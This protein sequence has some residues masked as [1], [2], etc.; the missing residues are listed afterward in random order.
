MALITAF[1]VTAEAGGVDKT[2][3]IPN[4]RV[5]LADANDTMNLRAGRLIRNEVVV[6]TLMYIETE[7]HYN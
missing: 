2:G 7:S 3:R 6:T 5:V 1:F 4:K